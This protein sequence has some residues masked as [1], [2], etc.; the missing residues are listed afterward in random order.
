M[1]QGQ[2]MIMCCPKALKTHMQTR[3]M[4]ATQKIARLSLGIVDL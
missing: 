3:K 1:E 2:A 4:E